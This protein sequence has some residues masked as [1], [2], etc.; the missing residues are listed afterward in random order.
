M[1]AGKLGFERAVI[2]LLDDHIGENVGVSGGVEIAAG[3]GREAANVR[4]GLRDPFDAGAERL[5]DLRV[6]SAGEILEVVAHD[7]VFDRVLAARAFELQQQGFLNAGG[8][9]ACGIE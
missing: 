8:A 4:G 5:G 1:L 6:T 7:L 9:D 2:V 3:I